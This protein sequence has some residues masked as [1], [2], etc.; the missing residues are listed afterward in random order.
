MICPLSRCNNSMGSCIRDCAF[1][2]VDGGCLLAAA[3]K[4]YLKEEK[5]TAAVT[6]PNS[7]TGKDS[8]SDYWDSP[9]RI[10]SYD[11]PILSSLRTEREMLKEEGY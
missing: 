9:Q 3:I 4:K 7:G 2:A 11:D 1:H 5:P 6:Y 8:H 10:L